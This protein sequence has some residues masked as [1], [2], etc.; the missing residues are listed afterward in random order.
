M[1]IS[2]PNGP[3]RRA[4]RTVGSSVNAGVGAVD[5]FT[6]F[7]LTTTGRTTHRGNNDRTRSTETV[8]KT[9]GDQ[10]TLANSSRFINGTTDRTRVES[11][12][13]TIDS[14]NNRT[15]GAA[16]NRTEIL[17]REG[18]TQEISKTSDC[19]GCKAQNKEFVERDTERLDNLKATSRFNRTGTLTETKVKDGKSLKLVGVLGTSTNGTVLHRKERGKERRKHDGK[20]RVGCK[21]GSKD[22]D[23][24]SSSSGVTFV[25]S[26]N[27]STIE[28][29]VIVKT[30]KLSSASFR[31]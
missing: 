19:P 5:R 29:D 22:C 27:D 16:S 17:R 13:G 11:D 8:D 26:V 21:K 24:S 25:N 15:S 18:G 28:E 7:S 31:L 2:T 30:K 20:S 1:V 10:E 6:T 9:S 4:T 23:F 14:I 3:A 12:V